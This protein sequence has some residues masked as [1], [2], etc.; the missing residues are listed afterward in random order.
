M[1]VSRFKVSCQTDL[2]KGCLQTVSLLRPYGWGDGE[3]HR[4]LGGYVRLG[5]SYPISS[6]YF[7]PKSVIFQYLSS[8]RLSK[9]SHPFSN[10]VSKRILTRFQAFR[11]KWLQSIP[12]F[13]TGGGGGVLPY[14]SYIGMCRPKGNGF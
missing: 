11:P 7:R 14:I 3:F 13:Q 5:S 10:P 6:P 4:I 9:N 12:F 1:R 8:D 2:V